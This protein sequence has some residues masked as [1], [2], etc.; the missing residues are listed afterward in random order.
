MSDH[1]R[2][3][4]IG[5]AALLFGAIGGVL[6]FLGSMAYGNQNLWGIAFWTFLSAVGFGLAM[7]M[8]VAAGEHKK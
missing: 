4:M 3:G 7:G 2:N 6:G 1:E 8:M 5:Y